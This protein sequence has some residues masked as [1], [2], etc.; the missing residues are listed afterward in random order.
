MPRTS[1]VYTP[2]NGSWT[3]GAVNGVLA[4]LDDWKALIADITAAL[5]QSLSKDG[6]TAV[7]SNLQMGGNKLT[8]LG[9]GTVAGDSLSW[10]QLF[11]QGVEADIASAAT[12]DIGTQNTNFLR[13][14]G[15]TTVTS[16]G[17]SYNGPRFLRF[18]NAVTLTNSSTLILPG[19]TNYT[20]SAGDVL[21]AM[22]KAT[23][24]TADGWYVAAL[25]STAGSGG[26]VSVIS[27]NTTATKSNLYVF[28]ASLTL[29]LPA[30][31]SVGDKVSFSNRSGTTTCVI[32]RNGQPIMGLAEDMT[33]DYQN[34]FGTLVYADATR[35][36]VFN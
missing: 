4:S 7:T 14:T 2:P 32:A 20:T 11:S 18:A 26:V 33:L 12:L 30:S 19:G 35:G 3:N 15:T 1:G 24:G 25:V 21:V 36:W 6:Q 28:T 22:P 9:K 31:P 16:L 5:T 17:T 8:N 29:T 34:H 13:V 23:A 27:T 10:E